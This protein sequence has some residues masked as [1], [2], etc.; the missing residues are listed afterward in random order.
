VSVVPNPSLRGRG[1]Q[2]ARR[3]S[4][5]E[6]AAFAI[7]SGGVPRDDVTLFQRRAVLGASRDG[8]GQATGAA[9]RGGTA[10]LLA[11][12]H[13]RT[14]CFFPERSGCVRVRTAEHTSCPRPLGTATGIEPVPQGFGG[15]CDLCSVTL[16]AFPH[17]SAYRKGVAEAPE[18]PGAPSRSLYLPIRT[19]WTRRSGPV[20]PDGGLGCWTG[21]GAAGDS[22]C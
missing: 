15:A 21:H 2:S 16:I 22:F 10:E 13:D 3:V 1:S 11:E 5:W 8:A 18:R 7:T 14:R 20:R 9:P 19:Q 6:G 17:W 12:L 4:W